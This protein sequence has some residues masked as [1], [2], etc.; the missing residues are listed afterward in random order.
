V[1][2]S[3]RPESLESEESILVPDS[4]SGSSTGQSSQSRVAPA[5]Q[6]QPLG[7]LSLLALFLAFRLLTLF[8]LRPGGFVRDW[9]DFDTYLGIAA[10]SDYGLYPFLHYWLEWPPLIPW[11][12]V[13]AYKLSL[14]LPLW[15]D[16]RLWFTLILGTVF[17]L[18]ET[19]NFVLL[20]RI[21]RRLL[22]S[23]DEDQLWSKERPVPHQAEQKDETT[24]SPADQALPSTHYAIRCIVL[25]ALLFAP[26]YA[27]LG[28]FD[29]IA[30]FFLLL[31][32]DFI[33]RGRL[34]SSAASVGVGFLVKLTPIVFL[35]VAL[36]RLWD[37]A[38]DAR[39]AL[40]DGALYVVMTALT[41][42]AL[43]VPFLLSNPSWLLATG[44]AIA[45]RSSWETVWAVMEG[46]FG[47]GVVAGDR[48]NPAE[49]SFAAHPSSLPWWLITLV[50]GLLYLVLW[51]RPANYRRPRNLVALTGLTVT[52]FLLYSKGYSPQF[53]VY[54]LPFIFLL[55]PN[56]RG[57]TYSLLLMLLNAL[58]QPVYF[59][60][61]PQATWLLEGVILARWL[62]L[63]ALVVE[64]GLV[65]WG[66]SLRRLIILRRYAPA[67][68]SAA[69]GLGLLAG[70]P[71]L[72]QAY[73]QQ[74][75]NEDPAASLIGYLRTDQA[76]AE[77]RVLVLTDQDLMRRLKPYL[78]NGY[79]IRLAGGDQLYQ[80]AS[81]VADLM[82][83][84][85]KAWVIASGSE[86]GRVETELKAEG[87]S[88]LGYDFGIGSELQLFSS[89]QARFA[90]L[91][92]VAR[93][94]NGANLIGYAI[95]PVPEN[96][97]RVTLYWWA[98]TPPTQS[99]TVFTQ[100]LDSEGNFVAGHD[101]IPAEGSLPTESW[102]AGRVYVDAHYIQ[103][104]EDLAA[105]A[106][107][108]VAGMY[109]VNLN[110]LVATGPDASV[111]RS[112]AVPLGEIQLR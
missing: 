29:A 85:E 1:E 24:L 43:L 50:F 88:L 32:L 10:L 26:V 41:I 25:Y 79:Q 30:L 112:R 59:I 13:G 44:R 75:L 37:E 51:T 89:D 104:P 91:P 81:S 34:L 4:R 58:E 62:I 21:A 86:A 47:Y 2:H 106:Y 33:L 15:S 31:A 103:V 6:L 55:F 66:Q 8:L 67:T 98:T 110:R 36:R 12:M 99:Y 40:R 60:L 77:S 48:L 94:A 78:H 71:L 14:L 76:Q 3:E 105:G 18:F 46:Y 17:V 65:L 61:V 57:V 68:L 56:A 28:F 93:L 7:F 95:E 9:S 53:L 20:Y 42:L 22:P 108:V 72:G 16:A 73:A 109:D 90:A 101:S 35:P 82:A 23:P 64:F 11:L 45:G 52:L 5:W 19:G 74:R 102:Q 87:R 92:P 83:D 100:L 97:V 27:M 54:L 84:T 49:T 39:G 69:V 96:R 63:G 80:A 70:I 107:Q 38:E 111:F